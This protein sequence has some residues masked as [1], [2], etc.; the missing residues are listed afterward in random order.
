MMMTMTIL[1]YRAIFTLPQSKTKTE[2]NTMKNS[3]KLIA[4]LFV[5][6]CFTSYAQYDLPRN[7]KG[8]YEPLTLLSSSNIMEGD[9]TKPIGI[10]YDVS[11]G[12]FYFS[13]DEIAVSDSVKSA[14]IQ[15]SADKASWYNLTT[16][17]C[18]NNPTSQRIVVNSLDRYIRLLYN[19]GGPHPDI[20]FT[21]KFYP[22]H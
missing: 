14:I 3:I 16:F 18:F 15:G 12:I 13:V 4:A 6:L 5:I 7:Y 22:K 11:N 2:G 8:G 21:V 19:V 1:I 9:S 17:T 10:P 20:K